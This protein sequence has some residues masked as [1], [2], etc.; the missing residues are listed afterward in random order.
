VAVPET[1]NNVE[2]EVDPDGQPEGTYLVITFDTESGD[3]KA[4]INVS[5]IIGSP[6]E[7]GNGAIDISSD[8]K[9][10]LQL[11]QTET[12][13]ANP[14]SVTSSGL[15]LK[16]SSEALPNTVIMRDAFGRAQVPAPDAES[17]SLDVATVGYVRGGVAAAKGYTDTAKTDLLSR[18]RISKP[19]GFVMFVRSDGSDA[20][21]GL[22]TTTAKATPQGAW[23]D[24]SRNYDFR[25]ASVTLNIGPGNFV[26]ASGEVLSTRRPLAEAFDI[27]ITGAGIAETILRSENGGVVLLTETPR[28]ISLGDMTLQASLSGYECVLGVNM[29]GTCYLIGSIRLE[30]IQITGNPTLLRS[31]FSYLQNSGNLFLKGS[32]WNPILIYGGT[33]QPSGT[34]INLEG[35]MQWGDSFIRAR[36]S[37]TAF[38]SPT[39]VFSGSGTGKRFAVGEN[40]L[41]HTYGSGANFLPGNAAGTVDTSTGGYYI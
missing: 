22:S 32:S 39:T 12:T 2:V 41:I 28:T 10:S 33:A 21:D 4:Y 19:D 38:I 1:V 29:V 16:A 17:G 35:A 20:A 23:D 24:M 7:P 14:L 25:G 40:S 13:T 36:A 11:D 9:I 26:A 6:Y 5:Q 18:I 31:N 27:T 30:A 8:Y 37:S 15:L 34:S 3:Q